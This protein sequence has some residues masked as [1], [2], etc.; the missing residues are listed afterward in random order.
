MI[1][2]DRRLQ[3]ATE[4]QGGNTGTASEQLYTNITVVL[5]DA[6]PGLGAK[7]HKHGKID[8]TNPYTKDGGK[9]WVIDRVAI[10]AKRPGTDFRAP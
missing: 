2:S 9:T 3:I 8:S 7:F 10:P 5:K 1:D 6:E 4:Y